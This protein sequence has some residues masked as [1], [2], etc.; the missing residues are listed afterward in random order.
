M[1]QQVNA[2]KRELT[3]RMTMAEVVENNPKIRKMAASR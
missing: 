2:A 1:G 3:E